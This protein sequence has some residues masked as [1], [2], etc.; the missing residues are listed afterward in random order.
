[1]HSIFNFRWLLLPFLL[2]VGAIMAEA[3]TS[4]LTVSP[5]SISLQVGQH[6]TAK[7]SNARGEARATSSNQKVVAAEIDDGQLKLEGKK[8]GSARNMLPGLRM[9]CRMLPIRSISGSNQ[10]R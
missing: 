2:L 1:M 3:A 8:A 5:A 9:V 10:L 4:S 7:V 6:G